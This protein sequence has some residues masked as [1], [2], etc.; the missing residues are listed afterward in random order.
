MTHN[1][2]LADKIDRFKMLARE[3]TRKCLLYPDIFVNGEHTPIKHPGNFHMTVY[4]ND[5]FKTTAF[6]C[7][8]ITYSNFKKTFEISESVLY[9]PQMMDVIVE[10]CEYLNDNFEKCYK[11][12]KRE[13]NFN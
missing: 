7:E 5:N 11:P 2:E 10:Q 1:D 12:L 13:L 8:D 4:F 6:R 9:D 3:I